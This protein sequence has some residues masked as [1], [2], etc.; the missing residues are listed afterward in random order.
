MSR[1]QAGP[2]NLYC[3]RLRQFEVRANIK[4]KNTPIIP[5]ECPLLI[6]VAGPTQAEFLEG[7]FIP[8]IYL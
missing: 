1:L 6:T 2:V 4:K 8:S 7:Y 3:Y 5:P